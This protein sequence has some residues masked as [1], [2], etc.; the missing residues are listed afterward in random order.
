MSKDSL[1][2]TEQSGENLH[3][4]D[5]RS[6]RPEEYGN[7]KWSNSV[8][9][10]EALIIHLLCVKPSEAGRG[11]GKAMVRFAVE[12]AKR[13]NCKV[14]RLDTRSQ[15]LPAKT[16]YTNLGFELSGKTKFSVGGLIPH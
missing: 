4:H 6:K 11:I 1:Y 2:V 9:P 7:I 12:E 13:R 10:S 16:L 5:H 8:D 15:N 14:V 3:K